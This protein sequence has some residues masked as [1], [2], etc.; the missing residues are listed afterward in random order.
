MKLIDPEI[1]YAASARHPVAPIHNRQVI[2]AL[3]ATHCDRRKKP[4]IR[5]MTT[6]GCQIGFAFGCTLLFANINEAYQFLT[7][8]RP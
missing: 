3:V 7:P 8:A 2:N 1:E 5:V 4:R 6:G